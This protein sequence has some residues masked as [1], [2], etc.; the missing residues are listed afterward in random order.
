MTER[1]SNHP[2]ETSLAAGQPGAL[3]SSIL[4]P[5]THPSQE[6]LRKQ[7]EEQRQDLARVLQ[8]TR[9][10]QL[11]GEGAMPLNMQPSCARAPPGQPAWSHPSSLL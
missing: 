2:V 7:V 4:F 8:V 9:D 3:T 6:A 10:A 1:S 5:P 11:G